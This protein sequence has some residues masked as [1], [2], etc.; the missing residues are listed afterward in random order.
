M[1]TGMLI[2][3]LLIMLIPAV[4]SSAQE[5]K[6]GKISDEELK[7]TAIAED[8][9]ANAVVLFHRG[10][11]KIT[12]VFGMAMDV[13]KR[14]KVLTEAGKEYA[15]V[16]IYY[17]KEDDVKNLQAF[18]YTPEGKKFKLDKKQIFE[19]SS[20]RNW[21]KK[22]FTIPGVQTGTVFEYKYQLLS[23]YINHLQPWVFQGVEFTRLSQIEVFLPS[24]FA[25]SAVIRNMNENE[26]ASEQKDTHN[27]YDIRKTATKF[28]YTVVDKPGIKEEPYMTA[29]RDYFASILFQLLSFQR[30]DG[31]KIDF[32]KNWDQMADLVWPEF[33]NF[34][35]QDG[36]LKSATRERIG[37]LDDPLEKMKRIYDFVREEVTTLDKVILWGNDFKKPADVYNR[38]EGG[39]NEKNMLLINML[40]NAGFDA[41]PL[42]ISTR[43]NGV[44]N[45]TWITLQQ[46]NRVI[47][48][49]ELD[50][51]NY[52]LNSASRYCPFGQLTPEYDVGQG[53]LITER[54][55]QIIPIKP[56]KVKNRQDITTDALLAD[57]GDLKVQAQLS[58]HGL[59]GVMERAILEKID[60]DKYL[61]ENIKQIHTDAVLDTF[62]Y[63][64]M[65]SCQKPL[66]LNMTFSV[67]AYAQESG[68]LAYFP[69]PLLSAFKKNPFVHEKRNFPVDYEYEY[70]LS[71]TVKITLADG[72]VLEEKP[73]IFKSASKSVLFNKIYFTGENQLE[74]RRNFK[75]N[76]KQVNTIEYE[77]LRQVYEDI[78]NS[79]MDQIVLTRQ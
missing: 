31:F 73:E 63:T 27:P 21:R 48:Y 10:T 8:P 64:D 57:N 26:F 46:F 62:S 12:P 20:S 23:K 68:N 44:I 52:F 42:L 72:Y 22:V 6:W 4:H 28:T 9:E 36:G 74:C 54:T 15:N 67:P 51:K 37:S 45:E 29:I 11:I 47:A 43:S 77:R 65:D 79:D 24:G 66:Q 33:K 56:L 5:F 16:A 2:L 60:I 1:R 7:M 25:Y 41:R 18:C 49:V 58:F 71:E 30:T 59:N 32:S 55:A 13:H 39:I 17:Y 38:K 75:I 34:V 19:Q 70:D 76:N 40:K 35:G 61:T 53:L 14:V 78:V 50:N 69:V 3:Y